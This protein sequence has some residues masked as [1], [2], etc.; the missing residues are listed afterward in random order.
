LD[1]KNSVL[2]ADTVQIACRLAKLL[3]NM[4]IFH[5]FQMAADSHLGFLKTEILTVGMVWRVNMH[6]C[7]KFHAAQ[8]NCCRYMAIFSIYARA[9]LC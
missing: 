5:I 2:T 3:P 4:T 9:T 8:S 7:A 1:L 6:R